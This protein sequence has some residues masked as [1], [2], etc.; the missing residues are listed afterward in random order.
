M[1][2]K[3]TL[4]TCETGSGRYAVM[5]RYRPHM[6]WRQVDSCDT[7]EKADA[8]AARLESNSKVRCDV[9]DEWWKEKWGDDAP[10][11]PPPD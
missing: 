7:V 9:F 4:V 1:P 11:I 6:P 10:L 8:E 3:N 2:V 5:A